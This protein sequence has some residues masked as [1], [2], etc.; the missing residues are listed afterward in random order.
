MDK[1]C[2]IV[3]G[4]TW[5]GYGYA[6]YAGKTIPAHRVA[7]IREHGAIPEGLVI[8]HL[9][10]NKACIEPS[11]LEAVTVSENTRRHYANHPKATKTSCKHGHTLEG[12]NVRIYSGERRCR[13]CDRRRMREYRK[14][15]NE[16]V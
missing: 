4:N 8:D 6:Y 14:R 10:E 2:L 16:K 15:M 3:S 7:Y 11:H 5:G 1:P 13:E 12:E 9:C